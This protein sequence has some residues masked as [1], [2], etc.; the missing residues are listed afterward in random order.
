MFGTYAGIDGLN[1]VAPRVGSEAALRQ[2]AEHFRVTA[3][4]VE[5]IDTRILGWLAMDLH[6]EDYPAEPLY[7]RGPDAKLPGGQSLSEKK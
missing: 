6:P 3:V 4:E 1:G 5:R 7:S 2:E